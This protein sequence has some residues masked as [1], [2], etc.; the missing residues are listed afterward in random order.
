M[1]RYLQYP[2]Y[3]LTHE[4]IALVINNYFKFDTA[5]GKLVSQREQ[6][7][8]CTY[9]YLHHLKNISYQTHT[10][11]WALKCSCKGIFSTK[12]LNETKVA[13]SVVR[14]NLNKLF[15]FD[16]CTT[17]FPLAFSISSRLIYT[18]SIYGNRPCLYSKLHLIVDIQH[19]Y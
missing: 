4:Q 19:I 13:Y 3:N 11:L 6:F 2:Q 9:T 5:T 17:Y 10:K 16:Y 7:C 15:H 12:R 1:N 14:F 18:S 8:F